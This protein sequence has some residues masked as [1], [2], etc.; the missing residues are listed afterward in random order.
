[1]QFMANLMGVNFRGAEIMDLVQ[2]L[3]VGQDLTLERD[4]MNEYDGNA[5]KVIYQNAEGEDIFIGFVAKEVAAEIAPLMDSGY[6]GTAQIRSFMS[7]IKPLLE[8]TLTLMDVGD[9][10]D[11]EDFEDYEGDDEA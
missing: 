11:E 6:A 5:V 2:T 8:I 10:D 9:D 7:P 3:Q 4:P 1:M